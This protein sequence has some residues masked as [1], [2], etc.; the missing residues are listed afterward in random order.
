MG[1]SSSD[2]PAKDG[3]K[4]RCLSNTCGYEYMTPSYVLDEELEESASYS[5][6]ANALLENSSAHGLPTLYRAQ[7]NTPHSAAITH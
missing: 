7:G 3:G 4:N 5:A 2:A 6:V 1:S